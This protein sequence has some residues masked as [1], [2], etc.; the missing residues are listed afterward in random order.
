ME[1]IVFPILILNYT[2]HACNRHMLQSLGGAISTEVK[3]FKQT[4]VQ[5]DPC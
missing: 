2:G 3:H 5:Q 1:A 4:K